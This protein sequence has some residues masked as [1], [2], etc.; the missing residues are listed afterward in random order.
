[1]SINGKKLHIEEKANQQDRR[2]LNKKENDEWH[3]F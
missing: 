1:M 2:T 3:I